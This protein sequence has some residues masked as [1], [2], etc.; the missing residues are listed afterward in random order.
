MYLWLKVAAHP[1]ADEE[2]MCCV[3]QTTTARSPGTETTFPA[4]KATL[5]LPLSA[6]VP[7]ASMRESPT[8]LYS[9]S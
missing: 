5:A 1:A 2:L 8:P 3:H 4:E 6:K 7:Y 9:P